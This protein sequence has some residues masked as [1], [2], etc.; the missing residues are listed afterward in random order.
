[1]GPAGTNDDYLWVVSPP[2]RTAPQRQIGA[3]Y[4]LT[5]IQ[6]VQLSPRY[7]RFVQTADQYKAAVRLAEKAQSDSSGAITAEDIRRQGTGSLELWITGFGTDPSKRTLA[8]VSVR[9]RACRQR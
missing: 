6:S 4:N 7:L 8:W 3:G 5:A 2:F 9:G 1:V